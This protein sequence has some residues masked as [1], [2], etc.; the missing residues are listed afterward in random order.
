MTE[1]FELAAKLGGAPLATVL[2]FMLALIVVTGKRGDWVWKREVDAKDLII[3]ELKRDRDEWKALTL[4][5]RGVA[6]DAVD[7]AKHRRS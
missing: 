1:L 3:D 7:I 2:I 4:D 6:R 5:V